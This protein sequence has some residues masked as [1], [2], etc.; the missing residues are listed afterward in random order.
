MVQITKE[1]KTGYNLFGTPDDFPAIMKKVVIDDGTG[2]KSE[3]CDALRRQLKELKETNDAYA[4]NAADKYKNKSM[5]QKSSNTVDSPVMLISFV[6]FVI[7]FIIYSV[8]YFFLTQ[9][10]SIYTDSI[11]GLMKSIME[12]EPLVDYIK[13]NTNAYQS[14]KTTMIM[15]KLILFAC[16]SLVMIFIQSLWITGP[17]MLNAEKNTNVYSIIVSCSLFIVGGTFILLEIAPYLNEIFENTIGYAFISTFMGFFENIPILNMLNI[18]NP[19]SWTDPINKIFKSTGLD[20]DT[21]RYKDGGNIVPFDFMITTM[22]L[23]NFR[24][25]FK[26]FSLNKPKSVPI[27]EGLDQKGGLEQNRGL[28]QKGDEEITETMKFFTEFDLS[29]I[30]N[31]DDANMKETKNEQTKQS[32]MD[33][34][35]I[36]KYIMKKNVVGHFVWIY[37]ACLIS[38][39]S[40]MKGYSVYVPNQ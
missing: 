22:S 26:K 1:V 2:S 13:T 28:S 36:A 24:Y 21:G 3:N 31:G 7:L 18:N 33:V 35:N 39:F 8:Y 38:T 10:S 32:I 27:A 15:D 17:F 14:T 5:F 16:M 20:K 19:K 4:A 23:G 9:A 11:D 37:F 30:L 34:Q 12:D 25:L 6:I 29:K 40:A